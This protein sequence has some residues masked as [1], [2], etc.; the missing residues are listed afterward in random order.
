MAQSKSTPA[1]MTKVAIAAGS[2]LDACDTFISR[3]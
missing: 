1:L 2:D 3:Y